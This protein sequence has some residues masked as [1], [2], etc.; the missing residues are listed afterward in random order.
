[1]PRTLWVGNEWRKRGQ[2][3]PGVV[4]LN[5]DGAGACEQNERAGNTARPRFVNLRRTERSCTT[6]I[7]GRLIIRINNSKSAIGAGICSDPSGGGTQALIFL[8]SVSL[9]AA[10]SQADIR[11]MN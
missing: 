9:R 6:Q 10:E 2:G 5:A 4:W 11:R 1:M 3:I 7:Y 8:S